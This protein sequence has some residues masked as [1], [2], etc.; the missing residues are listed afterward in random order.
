MHWHSLSIDEA[1]KETGSS[2][3]GLNEQAVNLKLEE[4]GRNEL[5][6][7]KKKSPL[8]IFLRQFF[9]VMI[10]VLAAAAIISA[11]VGEISD[12]F[13]IV[14]IIILNA[15]VGFVQEYRAE[16]A[17]EALQKMAVPVADVIRDN[18][19]IEIPSPEIVPGDI[20]LLEAGN[21]VPADIRLIEVHSLKA[22]EASLTGESN[23]VDK[24]TDQFRKKIFRRAIRLTW[25][26]KEP[27]LPMAA[28]RV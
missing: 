25:F 12:A 13:V 6:A 17:M 18:K 28:V 14:V 10:L 20:V 15:V 9:D 1:L 2:L 26:L 22:D 24:T 16:K 21:M 5:T 3:Q 4:H 7:K 11:V 19:T 8:L 23:A 27:L